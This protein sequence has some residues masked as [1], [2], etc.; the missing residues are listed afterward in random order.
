MGQKEYS[1]LLAR[2]TAKYVRI[3]RDA[4]IEKQ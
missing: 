4:R 3:G 2:E 1:E